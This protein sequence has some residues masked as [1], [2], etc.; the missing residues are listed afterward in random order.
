MLAAVA[1]HNHSFQSCYLP[2]ALSSCHPA[3][4]THPN[5]RKTDGTKC[6]NEENGSID[7]IP[8]QIRT[9]TR[10]VHNSHTSNSGWGTSLTIIIKKCDYC[11]CS[12][13][14]KPF[15]QSHLCHKT[16][17]PHQI[18]ICSSIKLCYII[19]RTWRCLRTNL[20]SKLWLREAAVTRIATISDQYRHLLSPLVFP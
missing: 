9:H 3:D 7:A 4:T 8:L 5:Q 16:K 12:T 18:K 2:I 20:L 15:P 17:R 13:G 6:I 10:L 11:E 1:I 14:D 19:E